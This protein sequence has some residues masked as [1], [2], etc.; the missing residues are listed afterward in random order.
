MTRSPCRIIYLSECL[1]K[2]HATYLE[3]P[4]E[5]VISQRLGETGS[6]RLTRSARALSHPL[7]P[8]QI[9]HLPKIIAQAQVTPHYVLEQSDRLGLHKLVNHVAQHG[10]DSVEAFIGMADVGEPGLVQ[11][12]LLDNKDGH[13]F[14]EF[15][16]CFH[17]PQAKGDDLG[18][19]QK[20]DDGVVV[21][22]LGWR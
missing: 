7:R 20:V 8:S 15:R 19:E 16:A 21:V 5:C 1:A 3:Q 12:N 6:Q 4:I 2:S 22:L 10:T 9:S 13:R 14:G 18:R 11:K 17:D